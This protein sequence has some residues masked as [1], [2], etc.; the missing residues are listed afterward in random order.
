MNSDWEDFL[1]KQVTSPITGK[2]RLVALTDRSSLHVVGAEAGELL[3]A[4][5]TQEILTLNGSQAA[6]AAFCNAKGRAY[7][8]LNVHPLQPQVEQG[9]ALTLPT[10]L[11]QETL[12]L[13]KLY[14]LRRKATLTE[15][16]DWVQI[17][18]IGRPGE[19][20]AAILPGEPLSQSWYQ[21]AGSDA[22]VLITREDRGETTSPRYSLQ[23]SVSAAK[24]MWMLLSTDPQ[25]S[26][27]QLDEWYLQEIEDGLPSIAPETWGHFV[28]QW[29]NLD[30]LSSVSFKKGC[31]PGQEVVAR[32]HYLG[33]PNRRM[34]MAHLDCSKDIAPGTPVLLSDGETSVGEVVRSARTANGAQCNLLA[35]VKLGHLNEPM[36][37][38]GEP[39]I[40][41]QH[42]FAPA[43]PAEAH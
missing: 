18:L 40:L 7:V 8:T 34:L 39:L 10:N 3:Q 9:Y 21:P 33:K 41:H 35:V 24:A 38:D 37:I 42:A 19:A 1:A 29:I 2:A 17:G 30:L 36:R 27:G 15:R 11:V 25:V 28:P 20:T 5:L 31:Y 32:M 6:R 13:L 12:K 14:V 23:G 43:T 16:D 22:P 4:M 26:I